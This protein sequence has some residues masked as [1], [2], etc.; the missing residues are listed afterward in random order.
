MGAKCLIKKVCVCVFMIRGFMSFE[1]NLSISSKCVTPAA[2]ARGTERVVGASIVS[3]KWM[4]DEN[5]GDREMV[6]W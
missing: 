5:A 3:Q 2:P 6:R 4:K 1:N